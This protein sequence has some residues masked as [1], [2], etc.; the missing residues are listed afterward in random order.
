MTWIFFKSY[1][2][3]YGP[4]SLFSATTPDILESRIS[5]VKI[6]ANFSSLG[7]SKRTTKDIIFLYMQILF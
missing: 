6:D 7:K 4:T 5:L 2:E 1:I 3:Y